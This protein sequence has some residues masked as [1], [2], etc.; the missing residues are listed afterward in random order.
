[1]RH[2]QKKYD[3]T[4]ITSQNPLQENLPL[5]NIRLTSLTDLPIPHKLLKPIA[6]R[7]IGDMHV[8]FQLENELRNYDII[9]TADPYYY[10]SY[11][12]AL[13]KNQYPKKKTYFNILGDK[14]TP[15]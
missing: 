1:M 9:H 6:N 12:A 3:L 11:Q 10:Y 14:T 4:C 15:Q 2:Y 13:V 8:L 5:R 7:T